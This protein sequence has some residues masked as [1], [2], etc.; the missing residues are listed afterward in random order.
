MPASVTIPAGESQGSF[1]L[2]A[3][4]V[5][6]STALDITA[7]DGSV[8]K[9]VDTHIVPATLE[10]TAAGG[11]ISE[12][13]RCP[14]RSRHRRYAEPER[15]GG[16]IGC[17]H[18]A[19][20]ERSCRCRGRV[21][22]CYSVQRFKRANH[23]QNCA[24]FGRND[25]DHLRQVRIGNDNGDIAGTHCPGRSS[26]RPR[27]GCRGSYGYGYDPTERACRTRRRHGVPIV[28]FGRCA[29]AGRSCCTRRKDIGHVQH[30]HQG[31]DR[32]RDRDHYGDLRRAE[33]DGKH[34]RREIAA[35]AKF[36]P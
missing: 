5:N 31:G 7:T 23:D 14:R 10:T 17:E 12:S 9:T 26:D 20:L 4:G 28:Q 35:V 6:A 2:L 8:T 19:H 33:S 22:G 18:C 24:G 15:I 11:L 13:V 3:E 30:R 34:S 32:Q 36:L 27:R 16:L 29:S 25:R 1:Q 21:D